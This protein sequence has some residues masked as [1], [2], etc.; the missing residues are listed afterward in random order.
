MGGPKSILVLRI[1]KL[2]KR[3]KVRG[4]NW[5]LSP[6]YWG[7]SVYLMRYAGSELTD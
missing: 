5:T 6:T 4:R 2:N 1:N 7:G 3:G